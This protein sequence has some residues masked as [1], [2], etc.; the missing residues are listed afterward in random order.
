MKTSA[1]P[2]ATNTSASPIVATV[3]PT[4]PGRE[5]EPGD[6]DALVGLGVRT[7]RDPGLLG[8]FRGG[9]HVPP[10]A[11]QVHVQVGG[12]RRRHAVRVGAV[13]ISGVGKHMAAGAA[14]A[15]LRVGAAAVL[16]LLVGGLLLHDALGPETPEA[17]PKAAELSGLGRP[18]RSRQSSSRR[19]SPAVSCCSARCTTRRPKGPLLAP[20][21]SGR[22]GTGTALGALSEVDA[23]V[24][25][26]V[27]RAP[28]GRRSPTCRTGPRTDRSPARCAP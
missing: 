28:S 17:K 16:A 23:P 14:V 19:R 25:L 24:G 3:S 22:V 9:A 8:A 5:L 6:L 11:S 12:G 7:Q 4:A 1:Q 13:R 10:H 20:E 26:P 21:S 2:F 15:P 27:D 18:G